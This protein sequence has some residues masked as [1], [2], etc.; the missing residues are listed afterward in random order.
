MAAITASASSRLGTQPSSHGKTPGLLGAG[1]P[2]VRPVRLARPGAGRRAVAGGTAEK[3]MCSQCS[4][5]AHT[6]IPYV[7]ATRCQSTPACSS[8]S[9]NRRWELLHT[10]HHRP[11][12]STNTIAGGTARS[13]VRALGAGHT[14][15][16]WGKKWPASL[17]NGRCVVDSR[18]RQVHHC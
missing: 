12:I 10:G 5:I 6:P 2:P 8:S 1:W 11:R 13:A 4:T 14:E 3:D 17:G 15:V 16:S 7:S 18:H 9:I